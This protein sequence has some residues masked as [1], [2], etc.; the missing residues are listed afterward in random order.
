MYNITILLY[1]FGEHKRLLL[2]NLTDP[3][4]LNGITSFELEDCYM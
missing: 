3:K 2:K 4:L 1:F